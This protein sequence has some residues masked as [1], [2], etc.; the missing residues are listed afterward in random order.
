MGAV[1]FGGQIVLGTMLATH[2]WRY[3]G[4]GLLISAG[5]AS[6]FAIG[7][8]IGAFKLSDFKRLRR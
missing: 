6:Y 4:L 8:L 1:L 3:V 7:V 5:I 2:G